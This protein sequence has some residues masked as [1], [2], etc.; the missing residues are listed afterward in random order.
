MPIIR[1]PRENGLRQSPFLHKKKE[2]EEEEKRRT[3]ITF[4]TAVSTK[5]IYGLLTIIAFIKQLFYAKT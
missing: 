1:N 3:H 2:Q 4:F 5:L